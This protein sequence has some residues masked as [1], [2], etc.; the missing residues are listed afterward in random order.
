MTCPWVGSQRHTYLRLL[1][2]DE[3]DTSLNVTQ[4]EDMKREAP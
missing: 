1:A 2:L 3:A 4:D